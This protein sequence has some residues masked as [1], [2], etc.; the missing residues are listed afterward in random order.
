D[1][2]AC[3]HHG[4]RERRQDYGEDVLLRIR[5]G[6]LVRA[7]EYLHAQQLRTLLQADFARAFEQVD[8]VLGPTMPHAAPSLGKTLE[9]SGAFNMPPRAIANRL[10]VPCNLTGMP[11]VSVPCGLSGG[12]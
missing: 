6:L 4:L 9:P 12:L 11:A 3:H 7:T 2:S 1:A 10:T 8:V 5:G